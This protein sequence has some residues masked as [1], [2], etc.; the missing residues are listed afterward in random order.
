MEL[1]E[2]IYGRRSVRKYQ[3]KPVPKEVLQEILESACMAPSNINNQPWYFLALTSEEALQKYLGYMKDAFIKF[4]PTLEARFAKNP[5]IVEETGNFLV[6]LGNAP[7]LILV[8]VLKDDFIA[9]SGEFSTGQSIAAA[10]E[11]LL[12]MAYDKGLASCWMTAPIEVGLGETLRAEFA[13]DKGRLTGAIALG[14]PA[15]NPKAPPRRAGR[16]DIV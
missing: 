1:K 7:V 2:A 10:V 16:F 13:P 11:N 15:Q 12:L 9:R 14:Y 4:K 3:N 6:T 8:F 5:E